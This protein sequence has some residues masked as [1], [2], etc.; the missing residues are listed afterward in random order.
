MANPRPH[1]VLELL[2]PVHLPPESGPDYH[3]WCA[4]RTVAMM[5]LGLPLGAVLYAANYLLD[6]FIDVE[7]AAE[8]FPW[9]ALVSLFALLLG[10]TTYIPVV[11]RNPNPLALFIGAYITV[12]SVAITSQLPS[13][14]GFA[15]VGTALALGLFA[16]TIVNSYRTVVAIALS[17]FVLPLVYYLYIG[18][19][20][21][22][23]AAAYVSLVSGLSAIIFL[24][25]VREQDTK[26]VF[27]M[28]VD[29]KHAASTDFLTGLPNRAHILEVAQ[30]ELARANRHD[31]PLS[32]LMVDIDNFKSINDNHGHAVGDLVL[33]TFADTAR[34]SI[35]EIDYAG[36]LGGEEFLFVLAETDQTGAYDVAQRIRDAVEAMEVTTMQGS[37][38]VTVSIG[39]TV[40]SSS[41]HSIDF[42]LHNADRALYRAKAKGRNRVEAEVA[43]V[44]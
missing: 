44:S 35:R 6:R 30:T 43:Y 3:A 15:L 40:R 12:S 32:F 37:V 9:R 26:R 23:L 21:S 42:L 27:L 18:P 34:R 33:R 2:R 38:T 8:L 10:M 16:I 1:S 11:R 36:R 7:V 22:D 20:P 29:L 13:S 5:Q 4:E 25:Y 24:G 39:V 19:F 14:S 31:H 17:I 28:T 41:G